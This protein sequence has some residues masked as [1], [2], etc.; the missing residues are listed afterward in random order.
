MRVTHFNRDSTF[1]PSAHAEHIYIGRQ[2]H[3]I[4][5]S[6]FQNPF[7]IGLDGNRDQVIEKYDCYIRSKSFLLTKLWELYDKHGDKLVF[8]CWCKPDRCHGD[9]LIEL[10]K[11]RYD[12]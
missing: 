5:A 12:L 11:E 7:K 6:P 3:E 8:G 4:P 1:D 10:I 2:F 9:I